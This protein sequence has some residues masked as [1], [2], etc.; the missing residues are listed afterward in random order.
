MSLHTLRPPIAAR[1]LGPLLSS[2]LALLAAAW[3][4]PAL[5]AD[6]AA[7][8]AVDSIRQ[9]A[10]GFVRG[11]VGGSIQAQAQSLDPRMQL[12]AC[13]TELLT[14]L[15]SVGNGGQ[16][17]VEVSCDTPQHW[18]LYVPVRLTDNRPVVVVTR[19][20]RAGE[21]LGT[22][23]LRLENRNNGGFGAP[24]NDLS[25]ALGR[26]VTR[27][28]AAGAVLTADAV[29]AAP[30]IRRGQAVTIVGS[31]GNFEVRAAGKAMQDGAPGERIAVENSGSRRI[32]QA[33]VR[34][35][36]LLAVDF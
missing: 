31:A 13:G 20:L 28:V 33:L 7:M 6:P 5:A 29:A 24:L 14:R 4:G 19:A 15:Q 23:D 22:Q 1:I 17:T 11:Q 26:T 35:D 34:D 2:M 8:Q 30:I 21:V 10:E 12:P 25:L 36:G 9:A 18:S 32:I 27:P 3:A 16:R